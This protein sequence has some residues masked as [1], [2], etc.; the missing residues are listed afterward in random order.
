MEK[1]KARLFIRGPGLM[2][3][4]V[5]ALGLSGCVT[6]TSSIYISKENHAACRRIQPETVDS[7]WAVLV[8]FSSVYNAPHRP[9]GD[10]RAAQ[11]GRRAAEELI[12]KRW[13][14]ELAREYGFLKSDG[15][16]LRL[17][18]LRSANVLELKSVGDAIDAGIPVEPQ[19]AVAKK[20]AWIHHLAA[21]RSFAEWL[22]KTS[23]K[24]PA[25]IGANVSI[26]AKLMGFLE[27]SSRAAFPK[28]QAL[29]RA[30]K[31]LEAYAELRIALTAFSHSSN[32]SRF[33]ELAQDLAPFVI[34]AEL[35]RIKRLGFNTQ[36]KNTRARQILA[37]N[38]QQWL[39]DPYLQ[40]GVADPFIQKVLAELELQLG[41]GQGEIWRREMQTLR[42]QKQFWTLFQFHRAKLKT[43]AAFAAPVRQAA[44]AKLWQQYLASL[45]DSLDH[46]FAAG[47]AE[48]E[49]GER[50]GSALILYGM[51][52][53]IGS[54][55][56]AQKREAQRDLITEA[57]RRETGSRKFIKLHVA[58]KLFIKDIKGPFGTELKGELGANLKE[59]FSSAAM[60]YGVKMGEENDKIRPKDYVL[61]KGYFTT[62]EAAYSPPNV[63]QRNVT[64]KGE[65]IKVDNPEYLRALRRSRKKAKGIPKKIYQQKF[66]QYTINRKTSEAVANARL[67]FTLEHFEKKTDH[68]INFGQSLKRTFVQ[69]SIDPNLTKIYTKPAKGPGSG[70][71]PKNPRPALINE[72]VLSLLEMK[73]WARAEALKIT[74]MRLL[75]AMAEYPLL[76]S[77]QAAAYEKEHNYQMA[78][79]SLG[80]CL[81][82]CRNIKPQSANKSKYFYHPGPPAYLK[83]EYASNTAIIK[84][85]TALTKDL[86]QRALAALDKHMEAYRKTAL[87]PEKE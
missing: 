62:L 44:T 69:E 55:L 10:L 77:K 45:Q 11:A 70:K 59:L 80:I 19:L 78:A 29:A 15:G 4:G 74:M 72:R 63:V 47:D 79:N 37:A 87:R 73:E 32:A 48:I 51:I 31:Y 28:I 3:A 49:R 57:A 16:R 81:E 54:F 26:H 38:R 42:E 22:L 76:I 6:K 36:E 86:R 21:D 13:H 18:D 67:G 40:G 75:G 30:K 82:Y 61:S 7:H 34:P 33:D 2:L 53:E 84:Q 85:F 64:F 14:N 58:R 52:S 60:L 43:A 23:H 12:R 27:T 83:A 35:T 25:K 68:R 5:L 46:F 20:F 41:A 71:L 56:R 1:T 8:W 50:H 17:L 39:R 66:F 24:V 9:G 65:I